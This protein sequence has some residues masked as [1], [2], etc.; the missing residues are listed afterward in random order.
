MKMKNS[1]FILLVLAVAIF[2]CENEDVNAPSSEYDIQS[3]DQVL[4]EWMNLDKPYQLKANKNYRII[5]QN[6]SE[7]NSFYMG[8]SV[9]SGKIYIKHIYSEQPKSDYQG[10]ALRFDPTLKRSTATIK[11]PLPGVFQVTFVASS[12]GNKGNEIAY[13]VNSSNQITVTE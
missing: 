1:L 6:D 9:P 7:Y 8:D 3:F 12:I 4:G 10:L 5:S 13:S 2:S 11:Y